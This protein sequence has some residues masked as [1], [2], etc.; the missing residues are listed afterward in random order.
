MTAT[1]EQKQV[2]RGMIE[3]H[4]MV[5]YDKDPEQQRLMFQQMVRLALTHYTLPKLRAWW[6]ILTHTSLFIDPEIGRG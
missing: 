6:A 1:T 2:V 4:L 3:R 5:Q